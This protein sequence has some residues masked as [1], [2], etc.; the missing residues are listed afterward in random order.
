MAKVSAKVGLTLKLFKDSQYEFI[1]PEIEISD[2]DT[3]KDI[4][5][6]IQ[7]GLEALTRVYSAISG[8]MSTI[9][10]EQQAQI[11]KELEAGK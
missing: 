9:V 6:Q 3:E 1:R 4:D 11:K 10:Y 8:R 7:K 5:E 2:I